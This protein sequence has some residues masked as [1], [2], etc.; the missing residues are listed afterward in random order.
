MYLPGTVRSATEPMV[1]SVNRR[2]RRQQA[3]RRRAHASQ[4]KLPKDVL[5]RAS[6][7]VVKQGHIV[8][9]TYQRN[10]AVDGR[11]AVQVPGREDCVTL[12]VE[13]AGTRSRAYRRTRPDGTEIDDV[14]AS[15]AGMEDIAGPVLAE[16]VAGAAI[17]L[18]A[19]AII[20]QFVAVQMLRGPM[21]FE[22]ANTIALDQMR[23]AINAESVPACVLAESGGDRH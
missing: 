3:D 20:A 12:K 4:V 8:A 19:K 17:D 18:Q 15:L 2:Q 6:Y 5:S 16:V 7:P 21:F 22:T 10:F 9:A 11:V 1:Q 23:D 14:E 13:N